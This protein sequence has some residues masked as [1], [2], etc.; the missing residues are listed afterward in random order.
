MSYWFY[1][2]VPS[3][4]LTEEDMKKVTLYTLASMMTE[5]DPY[6]SVH[7]L[8]E[9]SDERAAC[10][11]VFALACRYSSGR[12]LVEEMVAANYWP[13]V[14]GRASF[15]LENV[16]VPVYGVAEGVPFSRFGLS[17][18]PGKTSDVHH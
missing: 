16:N 12:D 15:K 4:T 14:K 13:L 1:I 5:M 6:T 3:L 2:Q 7:P 17:L 11:K 18:P 9:I 8:E 10:E